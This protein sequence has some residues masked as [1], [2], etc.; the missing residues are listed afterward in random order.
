MLVS[1]ISPAPNSRHRFAPLR[2]VF[3]DLFACGPMPRIHMRP[4]AVVSR[5]DGNNNALASESFGGSANQF[6][7]FNRADV[8]SGNFVGTCA[9]RIS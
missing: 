3:P 8:F 5:I 2:R 4:I 9:R 6:R 1:R 7:I